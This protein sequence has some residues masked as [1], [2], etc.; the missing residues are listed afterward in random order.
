MQ[1]CDTPLPHINLSPAWILSHRQ[2]RDQIPANPKH[3]KL[4]TDWIISA[5]QREKALAWR[6][7]VIPQNYNAKA[8]SFRYEPIEFTDAI[9]EQSKIK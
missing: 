4:H 9:H 5:E 8:H 7:Q 1:Y 6:N 3:Y 2:L